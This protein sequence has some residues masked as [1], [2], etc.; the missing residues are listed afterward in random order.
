MGGMNEE[1]YPRMMIMSILYI[2]CSTATMHSN[3]F[4]NKRY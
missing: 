2:G 4:E 3:T 1:K